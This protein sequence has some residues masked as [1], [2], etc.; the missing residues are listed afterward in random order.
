M[1]LMTE[2]VKVEVI[3]DGKHITKYFWDFIRHNK[4]VDDIIIVS[5]SMR[6]AGLPAGP[7]KKYKLGEIDVMIDDGVAWLTDKSAFAG[8]VATMYSN[9]KMLVNK[10]DVNLRDAVRMTSYNQ[11]LLLNLAGTVGE[12]KPER[13]ADFLLLDKDLNLQKIIKSGIEVYV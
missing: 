4:K 8:S 6:C 3:A 9:F 13:D 2:G 10:W 7:D 1:G 12:I 5:D 11:A